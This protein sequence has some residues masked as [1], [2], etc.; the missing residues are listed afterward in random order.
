MQAEVRRDERLARVVDDVLPVA[1]LRVLPNE[2]LAVPVGHQV[3]DLAELVILLRQEQGFLR[4]FRG[5]AGVEEHAD[6]LQHSQ[7]HPVA[8]R[9]LHP[10]FLR[11]LVVGQQGDRQPFRVDPVERAAQEVVGVDGQR[12]VAVVGV[13]LDHVRPRRARLLAR[14]GPLAF[15]GAGGEVVVPADD[16]GAVRRGGRRE[17][18]DRAAGAV[19]PV[20]QTRKVTGVVVQPLAIGRRHAAHPL[21][22]DGVVLLHVPAPGS[23]AERVA[24]RERGHVET[25]AGDVGQ[26]LADRFVGTFEDDV[27]DL[28]EI[29]FTTGDNR[30]LF[31]G[32]S[33]RRLRHH[34]PARG[35]RA[36]DGHEREAPG[37]IREQ[38]F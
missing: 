26:R 5:G 2:R 9:G 38:H 30:I 21:E 6:Y 13:H 33:R 29:L 23:R 17:V 32:A 36:E 1:G 4:L 19:E 25:L 8:G 11:Q 27:A 28:H 31:G 10:E 34:T 24:A 18:D 20:G 16:G 15:H 7:P 3:V 22:Q 12:R 37:P 35:E 14:P